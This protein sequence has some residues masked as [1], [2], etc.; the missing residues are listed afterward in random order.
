MPRDYWHAVPAAP[1]GWWVEHFD[2]HII[3][4]PDQALALLPKPARLCAI[5]GEAHSALGEYVPNNPQ[6]VIDYLAWQR[7]YKTPYEIALMRQA[8][9]LA[10]RGHRAAEAPSEAVPASSTSTWPTALRSARTPA[11]CPTPISSAST[12]TARCCTTPSWSE[13]RRHS[14]AA[15]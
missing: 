9:A 13:P 15:C 3:R 7:S 4:T 12:S 5:L 6:A 10:V 14:G 2:I 8:Q 1:S 11:S